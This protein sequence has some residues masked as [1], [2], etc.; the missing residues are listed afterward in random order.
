MEVKSY[1]DWVFT[2]IVLLSV[3]PVIP[4]PMV[5]LYRLVCCGIRRTNH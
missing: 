3:V 5:A 1:P 4:I 2:I